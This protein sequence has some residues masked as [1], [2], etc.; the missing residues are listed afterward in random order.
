M[1]TGLDGKFAIAIKD[2]GFLVIRADAPTNEYR[3]QEK[4]IRAGKGTLRGRKYQRKVGPLLVV[5]KKC[6]LQKA[7]KNFH[8][9][10]VSLVSNLDILK[11]AP[12]GVPGRLCIFTNSS[13]K[14]LQ[15][16]LFTGEKNGS[17]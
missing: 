10:D 5:S 11:L 13:I 14:A 4:K 17:T 8:G 3:I 6:S 12:G 7:A 15:E 2:T 16:G 9:L 1:L